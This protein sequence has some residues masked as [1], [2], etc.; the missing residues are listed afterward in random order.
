MAGAFHGNV[1]TVR[2]M[3]SLGAKASLTD[4]SG[5]SAALI[6]GM[7]GHHECFAELQRAADE[8]RAAGSRKDASREDFVY[9]LYYFEPLAPQSPTARGSETVVEGQVD[10]AAASSPGKIAEKVACLFMWAVPLI[11]CLQCRC[12]TSKY[13]RDINTAVA[14]SVFGFLYIAFGSNCIF[15]SK[16]MLGLFCPTRAEDECS[17]FHVFLLG[18]QRLSLLLVAAQPHLYRLCVGGDGRV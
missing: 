18:R 16:S 15:V 6:A 3:L 12:P 1:D 13:T 5:K 14:C 11:C 10:D 9:D 8:E 7:R 4:A 17:H 2:H